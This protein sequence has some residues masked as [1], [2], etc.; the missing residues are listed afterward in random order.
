MRPKRI[1]TEIWKVAVPLLIFL[2][3]ILCQSPHSS[4][5][6]RAADDNNNN[7]NDNNNNGAFRINSPRQQ[8][9]QDEQEQQQQQDDRDGVKLVKLPPDL[10]AVLNLQKSDRS[11]HASILGLPSGGLEEVI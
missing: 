7:Y 1:G 5:R 10:E 6:S 2:P 4:G 8:Q 3:L 9:Q 11:R